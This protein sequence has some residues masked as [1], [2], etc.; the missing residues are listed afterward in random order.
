MGRGGRTEPTDG[1]YI[2]R[3]TATR[4]RASDG[5]LGSDLMVGATGQSLDGL[6]GLGGS[7]AVEG[8]G[9]GLPRSLLSLL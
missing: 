1:G 6:D 9:G 8:R 4:P 7:E 3:L 2:E 5:E